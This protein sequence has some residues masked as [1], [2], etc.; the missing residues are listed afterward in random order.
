[1]NVI[2]LASLSHA[3][4]KYD[5]HYDKFLSRHFA[6]LTHKHID[7]KDEYKQIGAKAS[8]ESDADE[9]YEEE[10]N[11]KSEDDGGDDEEDD[12]DDEDSPKSDV[13]EGDHSF[14]YRNTQDYERIKALSEKEAARLHK[15]PGSCKSIEKDGMTCLECT[16]PDT[17][18]TSEVSSYLKKLKLLTFCD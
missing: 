6:D 2:L 12:E 8:Q 7:A 16:D 3:A 13:D 18:D 14:N 17:G 10:E 4:D 1:V 11:G 9:D 15:K 5:S